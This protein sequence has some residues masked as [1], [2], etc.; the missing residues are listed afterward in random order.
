[1]G[2]FGRS[3][4]KKDMSGA[5][6]GMHASLTRPCALRDASRGLWCLHPWLPWP[7]DSPDPRPR[8]DHGASPRVCD[9]H[10][11]PASRIVPAHGRG[12]FR[13]MHFL[14]AVCRKFFQSGWCALA[15]APASAMSAVESTMHSD[16]LTASIGT[17][18]TSTGIFRSNEWLAQKAMDPVV[19]VCALAPH[20]QQKSHRLAPVKA[21]L[22]SLKPPRSRLLTIQA[23]VLSITAPHFIVREKSR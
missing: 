8:R 4:S 1:M 20:A 10:P 5:T 14:F 11:L 22:A 17:V 3:G 23:T 15:N 7:E 2:L 6:I 19:Q 16:G 21:S 13:K 9:T 12:V 18:N